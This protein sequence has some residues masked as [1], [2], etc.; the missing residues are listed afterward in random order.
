VRRPPHGL[1][2]GLWALPAV[3]V[4]AGE[5]EAAVRRR[6]AAAVAAHA[7][8]GVEVGAELAAVVRTLS[9]RELTLVCHEVRS[10]GGRRP[11]PRRGLAPVAQAAEGAAEAAWLDREALEGAALPSA[12]RAILAAAWTTE[13]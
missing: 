11:P 7:G 9:H 2:G 1:F 5:G 8:G 4:A 12:F 3:E 13:R 10:A 6:L